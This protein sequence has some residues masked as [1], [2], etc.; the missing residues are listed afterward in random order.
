MSSHPSSQGFVRHRLGFP[1]GMLLGQTQLGWL[2]VALCT[3]N[4]WQH[5]LITFIIV[6]WVPAQEEPQGLSSNSLRE[7]SDPSL[8]YSRQPAYSAAT[9]PADPLHPA[10]ATTTQRAGGRRAVDEGRSEQGHLR[11]QDSAKPTRFQRE[12]PPGEAPFAS[13]K[14]V[15]PLPPNP[16]LYGPSPPTLSFQTSQE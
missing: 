4:L 3:R 9:T 1:F 13:A 7:Y 10:P 6:G 8:H 14:S 5:L 16:D 11:Q 12:T 2:S 15:L